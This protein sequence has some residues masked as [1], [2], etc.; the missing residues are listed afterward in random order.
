MAAVFKLP[1]AL[2]ERILWRRTTQ[3]SLLQVYPA[4]QRFVAPV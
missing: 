1:S 3:Q 2:Q 4:P